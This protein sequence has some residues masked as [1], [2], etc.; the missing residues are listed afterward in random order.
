MEGLRFE[1]DRDA[2][3][4]SSPGK[5]ENFQLPLIPVNRDF[6]PDLSHQLCSDVML[7]AEEGILEIAD[8][9]VD[10]EAIRAKEKLLYEPFNDFRMALHYRRRRFINDLFVDIPFCS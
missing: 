10:N 1:Q 8:A 5:S 2:S 7:V 6:T 3:T 9:F 4:P